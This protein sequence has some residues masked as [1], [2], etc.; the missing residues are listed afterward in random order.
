MKIKQ[1]INEN[2]MIII[3]IIVLIINTYFLFNPQILGSV[4]YSDF[5]V[6]PFDEMRACE[7]RYEMNGTLISV[8]YVDC[9]YNCDYTLVV[10]NSRSY[11]FKDWDYANL[12]TYEGQDV[13]IIYFSNCQTG[14]YYLDCLNNEMFGWENGIKNLR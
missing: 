13:E 9:G 14:E 8:D 6:N 1:V 12:K 5:N 7:E 10:I 4:F 2:K 3:C 11:N